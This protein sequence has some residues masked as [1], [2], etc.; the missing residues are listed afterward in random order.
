MAC[1][2]SKAYT[3]EL[4]HFGIV[5]HKSPGGTTKERLA[6]LTLEWTENAETLTF[7]DPDIEVLCLRTRRISML[8]PERLKTL[9]RTR[10]KNL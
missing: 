6:Y 7:R 5:S 3:T 2:P 1:Y 10:R 4:E 9:M 8:P